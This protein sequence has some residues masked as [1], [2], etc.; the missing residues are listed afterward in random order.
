MQW[1]QKKKRRVVITGLGTVNPTGNTVAESWANIKAGR[2]AVG[3]ITAFDTADFKVKLAAEVKDFDPAARI[4]KREARKMARFTQFAVAAADEA[5]RDSGLA[6]EEID[7]TRFGVILSSGIGGLPTI[8]EEHTRG[9]QRGFEKVSP[10][11]VP[12]SIGNMAAGQIAIR[13][14]LQGLC[15]CPT[16]ACAGGTNA[17]G[18]AF[19]RIRDGYED[20]MLCGGSE[21]C[22]S[23]LGVGGFASM[24]A[25]CTADDPARAS[26]PF[27][28]RRSG[29]VM[30][31]G[32]G[33]LLL[34]EL[35]AAKARGTK[36]Y[37][38]VVGY[39]ANCDAYHF[40]APAPDGA[41]GVEGVFTALALHDAFLPAT[42]NLQEPDPELDLD[43]TPGQ[44]ARGVKCVTRTEP[45]F[46]GHFPGH[47]VMPGVLILEALAQ[48]GAVAALSLPENR[49]KLA[50]FGGVKNAR[51]RRQVIP[52]EVLILECE[53]I[54]Q[55]GPVG[56]GKATA[57]V[58]GVRAANAELTFVLTDA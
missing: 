51:F 57:W 56:I 30:G 20:R 47:L 24:K 54:E 8:E 34:E 18:D 48:T 38:E 15:S 44:W 6:L 2:C 49:G 11:F 16:T 36:I 1:T 21:S 4:D 52:G 5:V 55:H 12:M 33:V 27:D 13:F 7:H 46:A 43:Y 29:F 19:H 9:Q 32:S 53:L 3:P 41:G 25:L 42:V 37:A 17:I 35:E 22:I 14:G 23:P 50:L 26:I 10:Y 45:F 28:A 58:D 39:S 31:E 40:T